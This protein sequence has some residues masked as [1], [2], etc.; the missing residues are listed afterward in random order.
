MSCVGAR[1]L[2]SEESAYLEKECAR[3]TANGAW[4]E[5]PADERTHISRVHLVPKKVE[6]GS[7]PK[8]RIVTDLRPTNAYLRPRSCKYETLRSLARLARRGDWMFSFDLQDGY[9]A[10]GIH[11]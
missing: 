9:F 5:A 6:P 8:W 3:L 7:P 4:V 1:A 2:S 11:G 10:V